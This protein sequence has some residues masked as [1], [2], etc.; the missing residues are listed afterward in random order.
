MKDRSLSFPIST[1]HIT[2][3]RTARVATCG[4]LDAHTKA[5]WIACHGYGEIASEFIG[6]MQ[7]IVDEHTA[8]IAPE[9]LSRFYWGGGFD[10]KPVASWMTREDRLNEIKDYSRYLDLVLNDIRSKVSDACKIIL[11]GFSQGCATVMRYAQ[12]LA[13]EIDTIVIWAGMIP[14]DIEYDPTYFQ[15]IK[16]YVRY[17]SQDRF[18]TDQRVEM[19][20]HLMD[21]KLLRCETRSFEGKHKVYAEPLQEL[22]GLIYQ[23]LNIN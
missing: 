6:S 19:H 11:F 20:K 15:S 9:A 1:H 22:K 4:A 5:V 23:E 21:Q 14:E 12:A 8:V 3:P 17:G 10:G 16:L 18:M 7:S 13:P 2:V